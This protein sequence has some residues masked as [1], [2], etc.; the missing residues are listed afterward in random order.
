[1]SKVIKKVAI[2]PGYANMLK[3]QVFDLDSEVG[4]QLRGLPVLQRY[5]ALRDLLA[6]N[7]IELHTYDMYSDPKEIDVW[8]MLE[9]KPSRYLFMARHLINPKKVIPIVIEPEIVL[10]WQWRY[11]R[12]W[13]RLHPI[14]LT[15]SPELVRSD[16]RFHRFYYAPFLFDV[17]KYEYYLAKPKKNLCMLMQSNKAS[18][19]PGELY[20]LRREI[21]RYYEKRGDNLFDLYGFGWNTPNTQHLGPS[22]PFYTPVHKGIADDKSETFA[23]YQFVFCIQNFVPA[24]DYESDV[25]MAMATGAVPIFLPPADVDELIPADAYINYSHFQNLDELTAY[26]QSIVGTEHYAAYRRR[27]WEYL[28]SEKFRPFTVQQFA[29]DIH[30]SIQLA[31]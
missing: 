8:L 7:G 14:V 6:Q 21:I 3:D 12:L 20:S 25:F 16:K 2:Y 9:M 22:E 29:E 4:R 27:G 17:N 19:V 1:M 5:I 23:E 24:G 31:R 10:P 11:M 15:W 26:L 18:R 28:N 13:S 30:R